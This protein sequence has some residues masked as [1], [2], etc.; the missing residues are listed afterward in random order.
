M[1]RKA[2]SAIGSILRSPYGMVVLIALVWHGVVWWLGVSF[3][4]YISLGLLVLDFLIA[5]V[6]VEAL[7]YFFSQFILPIHPKDRGEIYKRVRIFETGE[8]G[9]TLFV[10]NGQV[11]KHAGEE[12]KRGLG[13]I[14]LDTASAVVLRTDTEIIGPVGPGVK[15]TDE[16]EYI[17]N[18][19]GVDLRAQW[20]YIGP[21]AGD[22]PF[23][24]PAP[25]P[26][27]KSYNEEKR[28]L[29]TVG[30]TRDGF[31]VSPTIS[32]KYSIKRPPRNLPSE[33]G[34]T[35]RYGYDPT[36]V[37]NA[38][39]R[40]V[41]KLEKLNNK[42]DR[43]EWNKLPAHLV[44]NAW[45]EYI[46]K[47][48]LEDLFNPKNEENGLQIIEEM[49]NAR[50]KQ[51]HINTLD[52]TGKKTG[53][54]SDS[55]E[56]LQLKLRGIEVMEVRIHNVMYDP[57]MEEQYIKQW[58]GEWLKNAKKEEEQ[59][60]EQERLSM[61]LARIDAARNFARLA[62]RDFNNSNQAPRDEY[63]TLE[64]LIQPL[65]EALLL[66]SRTNNDIEAE[67]KKLEDVSKWLLVNKLDQA[68]K[69]EQGKA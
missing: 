24:N 41:I 43:M 37:R 23:L 14:V 64:A 60:N 13:V 2:A 59:I 36:A 9:Q 5:Y 17:A 27:S 62:S 35:S 15:F 20:Q 39:T 25:F 12:D 30:L 19:L 65:K 29:E 52:D 57:A 28:R 1:M 34:V 67:I 48:K 51:Q 63:S 32:I 55:M 47:F 11:I 46:R 38:V 40:E 56:Y 22:N 54:Q 45:R 42:Q 44:V 33:S 16:D 53:A 26:N 18:D 3:N 66:E 7:T 8:R 31:E 50:M 10:K 69:Q 4:Y 58:S 21:H 49:L 61:K 68:Q 6:L